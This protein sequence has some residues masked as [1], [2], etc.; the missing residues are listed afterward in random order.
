MLRITRRRALLLVAFAGLFGLA[1]SDLGRARAGD[2]HGSST[3][4]P[5]FYDD[6]MFMVNMKEMPNSDPLIR[7][8]KSIN[9]I[10][11]YADLDDEQPFLPILD[12]IQGDGFNPLWLQNL[13]VFNDGFAPHQ[14]TSDTDVLAAAAGAN[15]EI[16]IVVTDEVYRCSV[17]GPKK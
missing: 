12:A 16:T 10:Y 3:Q 15:P 11:A 13:I 6:Q 2:P 14:F 17:V 4:M 1:S 7:N 9:N 5:A 8:N